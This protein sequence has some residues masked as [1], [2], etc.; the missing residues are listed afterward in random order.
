VETVETEVQD[1]S[2][3]GS[4]GVPQIKNSPKTGGY[5]GLIKAISTFSYIIKQA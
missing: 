4:V 5:R 2:C 1:T 3:R